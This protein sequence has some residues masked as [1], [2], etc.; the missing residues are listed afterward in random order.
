MADFPRLPWI[1]YLIQQFY[2]YNAPRKLKPLKLTHF[3]HA[4]PLLY[5]KVKHLENCMFYTD[6][7]DPFV[8]ILPSDRHVIGKLHTTTIEQDN[9]NTR[10]HLGR[11]TRRTKI[12]SKNEE[13]IHASMK[14]RWGLTDPCIFK[15]YQ[16]IVLS[17][18]I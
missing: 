11:T 18:F 1:F 6:N 17:I 5:D 8:K 2:D 10:H 15:A 3:F 14:L 13:M 16:A 12:V 7:R 4:K 9:S